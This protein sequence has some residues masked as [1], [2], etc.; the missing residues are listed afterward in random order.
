MLATPRGRRRLESA[1][2][3]QYL[4]YHLALAHDRFK[5]AAPVFGGS[6]QLLWRKLEEE[7]RLCEDQE[8]IASAVHV[9][10]EDYFRDLSLRLIARVTSTFWF[11]FR[12]ILV[13][14]IVV[15]ATLFLV[16]S[17]IIATAG[18]LTLSLFATVAVL[19]AAR[20]H[21]RIKRSEGLEPTPRSLRRVDWVMVAAVAEVGLIA[22]ACLAFP[23][24]FG[25]LIPLAGSFAGLLA[26]ITLIAF[27]TLRKRWRRDTVA[28]FYLRET[29]PIVAVVISGL[30]V[31]SLIVVLGFLVT[32]YGTDI[33]KWL[34]RPWEV[35]QGTEAV[36]DGGEGVPP[37]G[38]DSE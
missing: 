30:A 23:D 38:A 31:L 9:L 5:V 22:V 20:L 15:K 2:Y 11:L 19:I 36:T 6:N 21:G 24:L 34:P 35:V 1:H 28:Q 37:A 26:L 8:R 3:L 17:M 10:R 16:S 25:H 33:L 18:L 27:W 7:W 4:S 32:E 29:V 12:W 14:F 13:P